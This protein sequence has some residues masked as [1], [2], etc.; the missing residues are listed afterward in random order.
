[1]YVC[2]YVCVCV[3]IY[4][5]I[6]TGLELGHESVDGALFRFALRYLHK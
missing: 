5:Y 6:G 1:M 2:M 3:Y 4:I